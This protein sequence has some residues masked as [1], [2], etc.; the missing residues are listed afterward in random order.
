MQLSPGHI[1]TEKEKIWPDNGCTRQSKHV[2][3]LYNKNMVCIDGRFY[4]FVTEKM[5]LIGRPRLRYIQVILCP[6]S[7]FCL[8]N[9]LLN[10]LFKCCCKCTKVKPY[11]IYDRALCSSSH[12][13]LHMAATCSQV[14]E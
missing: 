14:P 8:N 6:D 12:K 9:R 7:H 2:A 13:H 10:W 3:L 11:L 4:A 5:A 1:K